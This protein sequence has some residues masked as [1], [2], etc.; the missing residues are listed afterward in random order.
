MTLQSIEPIIIG[1]FYKMF[2]SR[3][4]TSLEGSVTKWTGEVE[5]THSPKLIYYFEYH[6]RRTLKAI[7]YITLIAFRGHRVKSIQ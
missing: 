6:Q 7:T 2:A 3:H 5:I 4:Y 1:S